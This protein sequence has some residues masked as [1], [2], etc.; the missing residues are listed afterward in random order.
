MFRPSCRLHWYIELNEVNKAVVEFVC[1][2][3]FYWGFLVGG[4]CVFK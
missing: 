3:C 2:L 4:G 1:E